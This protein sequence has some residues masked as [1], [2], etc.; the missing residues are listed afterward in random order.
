[1]PLDDPATAGVEIDVAEHRVTDQ[2]GW[3]ALR[4]LVVVGLNWN[5]YGANRQTANAV[6]GAPGGAPIQGQWHTYGVL[7]TES[8]YTFY[9]DG[10]EAWSTSKAISRHPQHL[11]LTCEVDDGTWAG[12]VPAG[13]YGPRSTSTTRMQVDWVRVW[14]PG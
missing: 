8:G 14:Q 9:V 12:W 5:G 1:M 7:W 13:G 3:T 4:D 11:M 2:G 10:A 6:V